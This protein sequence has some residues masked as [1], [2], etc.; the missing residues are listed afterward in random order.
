MNAISSLK[1]RLAPLFV[2]LLVGAA[3][4]LLPLQAFAATSPELINKVPI[5]SPLFVGIDLP[6]VRD[7]T[8]FTEGVTF[9]TKMAPKESLVAFVLSNQAFDYKTD[10]DS[11]VIAFE[12][13]PTSPSAP[14]PALM[15]VVS[16][17]F[18]A[19]RVKKSV[20]QR[21]GQISSRKKDGLD[22]HTSGGVDFAFLDA[23]T[24]VIAEKKYADP[25]WAAVKQPAKAASANPQ[26]K[27]LLAM[28]DTS[29]GF[30]FAVNAQAVPTPAGTPATEGASIA[31]DLRS[32]LTLDVKTKFAKADDAKTSL[33]KFEEL[34]SSQDDPLIDMLGLTPLVKN[35]KASVTDSRTLTLS[36]S[37]TN[38]EVKVMLERIRSMNEAPP[39]IAPSKATGS[40][41]TPKPTGEGANADFN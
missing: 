17:K 5:A 40:Q 32:G 30:W 13:A 19:D 24:L 14:A 11:A 2:V 41:S 37:M 6:L 12:T 27:Q 25:T 16:G 1:L 33:T 39:P 9:L 21:Y 26:V 10:I 20:A 18:D 29:R 23:N 38:Y 22:I 7:T 3:S 8:L 31:V 4:M 35:S 34:K 15:A 28:T 36:S